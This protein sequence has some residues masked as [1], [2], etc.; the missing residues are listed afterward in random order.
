MA[1]SW[2]LKEKNIW[3]DKENPKR[4]KVSFYFYKSFL[5]ILKREYNI[6]NYQQERKQV[7]HYEKN[8]FNR[9]RHRRPCYT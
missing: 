9:R 5:D 6:V 2:E 1:V 8:C 3:Q 4:F 7:F